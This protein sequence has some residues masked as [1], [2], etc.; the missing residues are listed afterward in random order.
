MDMTTATGRALDRSR[1]DPGFTVTF[2]CRR[3]TP[4]TAL[5]RGI[6]TQVVWGCASRATSARYTPAAIT[7]LMCRMSEPQHPPTTCKSGRR[8]AMLA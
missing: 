2:V 5:A 6:E 1:R 7:A 4:G 8:F 3:Q